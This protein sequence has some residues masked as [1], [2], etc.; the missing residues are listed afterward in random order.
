[1]VSEGIRLRPLLI[2]QL[3]DHGRATSLLR[4]A[5]STTLAN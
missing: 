4:A 5:A 2:R 1:V 3:D